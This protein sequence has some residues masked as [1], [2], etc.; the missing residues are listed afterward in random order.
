M[1]E[2][3]EETKELTKLVVSSANAVIIC[4]T[5]RDPEGSVM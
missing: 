2:E 5:S 1:D 3:S 4:E